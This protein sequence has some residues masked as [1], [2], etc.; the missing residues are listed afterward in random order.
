MIFNTLNKTFSLQN[1]CCFSLRWHWGGGQRPAVDFVET[2]PCSCRTNKL[3]CSE[4]C[5]KWS[6]VCQI[7]RSLPEVFAP[8]VHTGRGAGEDWGCLSPSPAP[9]L[10][11]SRSPA[12]TC[13]NRGTAPGMELALRC[14]PSLRDKLR[15]WCNWRTECAGTGKCYC[16]VWSGRATQLDFQRLQWVA[17]LR[18]ALKD[19]CGL[20]SHPVPWSFGRALPSHPGAKP[21]VFPAQV[22]F[23]PLG[24]LQP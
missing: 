17:S 2:A 9:S 24:K 3:L 1:L 15:L 6:A 5:C 19:G 7:T 23:L 16:I 4:R 22:W 12:P 14:Q 18:V 10:C 8:C 13:R 11:S 21:V 20:S